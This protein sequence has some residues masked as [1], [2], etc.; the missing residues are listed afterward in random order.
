MSR[1]EVEELALY[2]AQHEARLA[3]AHVAQKHLATRQERAERP[4]PRTEWT[5]QILGKRAER[6]PSTASEA[7]VD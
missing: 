4:E 2:K 7:P 3:S 6:E 1:L 5:G